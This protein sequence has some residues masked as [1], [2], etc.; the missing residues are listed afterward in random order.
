MARTYR[1]N[2][3]EHANFFAK[4]KKDRGATRKRLSERD[5]E[6]EQQY[7]DFKI[8]TRRSSQIDEDFNY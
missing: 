6:L 1:R 8:K 4:N 2:N 7:K 5:L 3:L